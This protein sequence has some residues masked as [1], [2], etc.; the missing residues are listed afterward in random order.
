MVEILHSYFEHAVLH[1][2]ESTPICT[3]E[4]SGLNEGN[5]KPEIYG[6]PR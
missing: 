2:P 6:D 1:R 3:F 5:H 4:A